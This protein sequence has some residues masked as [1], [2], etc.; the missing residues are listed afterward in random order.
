MADNKVIPSTLE[1]GPCLITWDWEEKDFV[2][3]Y[4]SYEE[5]GTVGYKL[6]AKGWARCSEEDWKA[7][8]FSIQKGMQVSLKKAMSTWQ[9]SGLPIRFREKIWSTFHD[10]VGFHSPKRWINEKNQTKLPKD[11]VGLTFA[12]KG[13]K[14]TVTNIVWGKALRA[15][16]KRRDYWRKGQEPGKRMWVEYVEYEPHRGMEQRFV[17]PKSEFLNKFKLV[18]NLENKVIVI[19]DMPDC[20]PTPNSGLSNA[21]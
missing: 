21:F 17:R 4:V 13:E 1:I 7:G 6:A 14:Y 19:E 9:L 3:C 10:E 11:F 18:T 20:D 16:N 12:Y 8:L 15:R 5:P 2:S